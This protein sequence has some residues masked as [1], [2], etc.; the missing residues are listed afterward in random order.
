MTEASK[1]T[2]KRNQL[3]NLETKV[4]AKTPVNQGSL[5]HSTFKQPARI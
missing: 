3:G 2:A 4:A 1:T 5:L